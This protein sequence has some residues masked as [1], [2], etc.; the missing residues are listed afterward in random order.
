MHFQSGFW[1]SMEPTRVKWEWF[2]LE[3][4]HTYEEDRDN[5]DKP[6][7]SFSLSCIFLKYFLNSS[8]FDLY[9]DDKTCP[10]KENTI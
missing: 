8:D 7:M 9:E 4:R 2:M 3:L 10:M 1:W 6:A 5:L